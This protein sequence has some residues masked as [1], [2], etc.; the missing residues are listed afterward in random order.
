MFAFSSFKNLTEE[1]ILHIR[2][3]LYTDTEESQ[4][5]R[6]IVFPDFE[7]LVF[8]WFWCLVV[9]LFT[10]V[11]SEHLTLYLINQCF[12]VQEVLPQNDAGKRAKSRSSVQ[13]SGSRHFVPVTATGLT[14]LTLSAL[15]WRKS[16]KINFPFVMSTFFCTKHIQFLS[17]SCSS[18][19]L[20]DEQKTFT[21]ELIPGSWNPKTT[22]HSMTKYIHL[23]KTTNIC[24]RSGSIDQKPESSWG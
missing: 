3:G 13:R 12:L 16:L 6:R 18:V 23:L 10:F 19:F 4:N 24:S 8:K 5:K 15:Q 2:C 1:S 20:A 22:Q 17:I 9:I 11:E 14:H 21:F 7:I